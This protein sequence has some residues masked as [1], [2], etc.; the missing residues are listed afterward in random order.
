MIRRLVVVRAF[1]EVTMNDKALLA[2]ADKGNWEN[3]P[4]TGEKIEPLMKRFHATPPSIIELAQ[5]VTLLARPRSEARDV[6]RAWGKGQAHCLGR[7]SSVLIDQGL[8]ILR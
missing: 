5:K 4:V 1:F 3:T 7:S 2:E 6:R 8:V